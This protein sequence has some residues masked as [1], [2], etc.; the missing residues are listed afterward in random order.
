MAEPAAQR[1]P[2][3]NLY[4][5][6]KFYDWAVPGYDDAA[7]FRDY[8]AG[9]ERH[10]AEAFEDIRVEPLFASE[11]IDFGDLIARARQMDPTYEPVNLNAFF[12]IYMPPRM[13]PE[14]LVKELSNWATVETAYVDTPGEEACNTGDL[15]AGS[16]G[17]L[18]PAPAGIDARYAWTVPGGNGA[19]GGER[20]LRVIDME[21]GWTL[22]HE[23]LAVHGITDPPAP[24]TIRNASRYH[25]TEA[26]GVV[27]ARRDGLTCQGIVPS[28]DAV[29][30]VSCW[31]MPRPRA[32]LAAVARLAFGDVLL[33]EIQ[34]TDQLPIEVE[35]GDYVMIR[36]ATALGIVVV[37]LAGNRGTD[38]QTGT[39][40]P[41]IAG[42]HVR[43]SGA[44]LVSCATS[45]Y[46]PISQCHEP[47][48]VQ[49]DRLG[50][51]GDRVDCYAWGQNVG[52]SS[53]DSSGCTLR[54]VNNFNATSAAAAIIAGAALSVQGMAE[55]R[56][57]RRLSPWQLRALLSDP[58]Y[59]TCATDPSLGVMPDLSS[60]ARS[61]V[62]NLTADVYLRDY[63]GDTG[64]PHGGPLSAS[65]D[66]ILRSAR[67]RNPQAAFGEGSGTENSNTLGTTAE[68]EQD[69]Y[70]YVRA[71][72]RGGSA[73]TDVEAHV[74][75]SPPATLVTPDLWTP[76]GSVTLPKVPVGDVLTVSDPITWS[77]A[78]VPTTGHYC[79]VGILDCD[80]DP[81][82][83]DPATVFPN[84]P[85]APG[86]GFVTWDNY[87]RFIRENN[88]VTWRNLNVVDDVPRYRI[89]ATGRRVMPLPFLAPGPPDRARP[90]RL[91]IGG[92]LPEGAELWLEAPVRLLDALGMGG[93]Y[94]RM[95]IEREED[96]PRDGDFLQ[97]LLGE[98][99]GEDREV[100]ALRMNPHGRSLFREVLF[101]ARSRFRLRLLAHVPEEQRLR[102]AYEVFARQLYE[103]EEVGRVTWRIA[104]PADGRAR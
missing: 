11:E 92:K 31:G 52:T 41:D 99:P 9:V 35:L 27:C 5:I 71:R 57:G 101:P 63:V 91:E 17:Y 48:Y 100:M 20:G 54:Y 93:Q 96:E 53:S 68:A 15:C 73:A 25:G 16:Q 95:E 19:T 36:L 97:R 30:V 44:I 84:A 103:G 33:I 82:P 67:V 66:L 2:G 39:G 81:F 37:E 86:D 4:V 8:R 87:L 42:L 22:E 12:V 94:E 88:N 74:Y 1:T 69:N 23:A 98:P 47:V 45:T 61:N 29:G 50:N 32:L 40:R 24:G 75:W 7:A 21:R 55:A 72:N 76:V 58:A 46:H 79:L 78:D 62:L 59:G 43:D 56:L 102:H 6:V 18:N 51:Y 70:V 90:M 49:G 89:R 65:P 34:T 10:L 13:D 85:N 28:I 80:E 14:I 3:Y 26:L 64:D 38:L 104:P 83:F 60:I 77:A